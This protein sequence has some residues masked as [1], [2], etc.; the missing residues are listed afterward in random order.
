M[1]SILIVNPHVKECGIYQYGKRFA[2]ISKKSKSFIFEYVE[3]NSSDDLIRAIYEKN[4]SIIIYNYV[5][6]TMIWVNETLLNYIK[7]F[8]IMQGTIVHHSQEYSGFDFYLHQDPYY[9]NNHNHYAILRPLFDYIP[10]TNVVQKNDTIK[11]GTFGFGG[12]NKITQD[13][14]KLICNEFGSKNIQIELNF[15]ITEAFYS[16][17]S[18]DEIKK[19]C[20]SNIVC[21]NVKLNMTNK[22]LSDD[23]ILDFLFLN[24]LNIFFYQYYDFYNGISSS[25]DYA[26]SVKKPIAICKSNMF[27]HIWD[28]KPSICV[29]ENPLSTI[30]T[31]GFSPLEEKYNSWSNEKFIKNIETIIDNIER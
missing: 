19:E 28:V 2:N 21:D 3:L 27:S 4:I 7:S 13:I 11:I 14:C 30:I 18:L 29:E 25:I 12:K 16:Q 31:N 15:H 6:N 26:L 17:D 1:K 24:D 8:G 20:L 10:K 22:F 23:E 9:K 5:P